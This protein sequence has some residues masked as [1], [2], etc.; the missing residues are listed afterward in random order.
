MERPRRTRKCNMNSDFLYNDNDIPAATTTSNRKAVRVKKQS[1]M[2]Q[3]EEVLFFDFGVCYS[4]GR[5]SVETD[6]VDIQF[7]TSHQSKWTRVL[8]NHFEHEGLKQ[9]QIK[10]DLGI[11]YKTD[12]VSVYVYKTGIVLIQG[13]ECLQW[14]DDNYQSLKQRTHMVDCQQVKN[15]QFNKLIKWSKDIVNS[16]NR[17]NNMAFNVDKSDGSIN[18]SLSEGNVVE[19]SCSMPVKN[20]SNSSVVPTVSDGNTYLSMCESNVIEPSGSMPVKNKSN[21]SVV[22]TISDGSIH[23]SMC[24]SNL[25]EPSGSISVKNKSY[26]SVVPTTS[27]G[28]INLSIPEGSINLSIPEGNVIEPSCS[29][30]MKDKSNSSVVPTISA[31]HSSDNNESVH[32][33]QTDDLTS[34]NIIDASKHSSI[35]ENVASINSSIRENE[36]NKTSSICEKSFS[37]MITQNIIWELDNA[38]LK[39][40]IMELKGE[41][42]KTV[43]KMNGF[44]KERDI[45]KSKLSETLKST[46]KPKKNHKKKGKKDKAILPLPTAR[47]PKVQ[48][49]ICSKTTGVQDKQCLNTPVVKPASPVKLCVNNVPPSPKQLSVKIVAEHSKR[50]IGSFMKK[51]YPYINST[52]TTSTGLGLIRAAK[53][54]LDS[55]DNCDFVVL[56]PDCDDML[57]TSSSVNR[58][59]MLN[60]VKNLDAKL[61]NKKVIISNFV[62]KQNLSRA[63]RNYISELNKDLWVACG[64][65]K[66][67]FFLD[68]DRRDGSSMVHPDSLVHFAD[69]LTSKIE[70]LAPRELKKQLSTVSRPVASVEPINF[71]NQNLIFLT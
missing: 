42:T 35:C 71:H 60:I 55:G 65:T 34:N 70:F 27:D 56:S 19:T 69:R 25:I 53:I 17:S 38:K 10:S 57:K 32:F 2:K 18:L 48:G 28:S 61:S 40:E 21:S 39:A 8:D 14:C 20:I 66:N 47:T 37:T 44:M 26:S 7:Y 68:V 4:A 6:P 36:P 67:V 11:Q 49:G 43:D 54:A 24:D 63:N 12:N 64:E 29:T 30:P 9:V 58:K 41:L 33:A 23:L 1:D 52:A 31:I 50:G 22:P 59:N 13:K 51:T 46:T 45:L 16:F 62:P 3:N 15:S 5:E